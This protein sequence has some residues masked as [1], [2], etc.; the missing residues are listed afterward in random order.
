MVAY[1]QRERERER[2]TDRDTQRERRTKRDINTIR[3]GVVVC[4]LNWLANMTFKCQNLTLSTPIL[5]IYCN[6]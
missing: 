2:Q 4:V 5:I 6:V 1:R 3:T